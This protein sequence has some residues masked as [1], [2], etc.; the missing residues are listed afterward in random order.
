MQIKQ[1]KGNKEFEITEFK[2]VEENGKVIISGYANTKGVADRYGDIPTPFNRTYV[3]EL[4]DYRRNP[5]I[6]LNHDADIKNMAGKCIEIREDEKGLFFKA[7]MT[8]S[9]LPIM[10]HTRTVI[11]EKILRTVSIGGMWL[12]E[13][14]ANPNHLTLAKI[15]EI[16]L[17]AIPAD[18]FATFEEDSQTKKKVEEE[19]VKVDYSEL[20]KKL[21]V[22]E[23]KQK[24]NTLE[25]KTKK[26]AKSGKEH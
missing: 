8:S 26:P 24:L 23:M 16:S 7:E 9:K 2:A 14:L 20:N 21:A 11:K 22:F 5:I 1:Y 17:V 10:E 13:D 3:Y 6:L 25:V 18:P 12:F 19:Q 4:E 15:F